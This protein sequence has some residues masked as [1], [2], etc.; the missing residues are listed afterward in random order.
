VVTF[1]RFPLSRC[2]W[3]KLLAERPCAE[4]ELIPLFERL[5]VEGR[6][7]ENE[8]REL[9]VAF[10]LPYDEVVQMWHYSIAERYRA[11]VLYDRFAYNLERTY[12]NRITPPPSVQRVSLVNISRGIRINVLLQIALAGPYR[13]VFW[14]MAWPLLRAGRMRT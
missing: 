9:N 8:T 13:R 2:R 10:R 3:T 7:V 12:P 4:R 11:E 1:V 6:L 5:Q 14:R